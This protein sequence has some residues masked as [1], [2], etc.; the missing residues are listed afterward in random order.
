MARLTTGQQALLVLAHCATV[1]PTPAWP[2]GSASAWPPSTGTSE[3]QPTCSPHGAP[4]LTA[5]LCRPGGYIPRSA[6]VLK[7]VGLLAKAV[8]TLELSPKS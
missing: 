2:P 1:I 6:A 7:R 5:T 8:L 4:S 3:R